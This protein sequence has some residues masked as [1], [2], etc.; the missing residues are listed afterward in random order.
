MTTPT[1]IDF[2]LP[3]SL[4][5]PSPPERRGV[6]RD[7]VR[8]MVLNSLQNEQ[9]H[10]YFYNL[11]RY[12]LPGDVIVLNRSRTIPAVLYATCKTRTEDTCEIRLAKKLSEDTWGVLIGLTDVNIGE[13][14]QIGEQLTATVIGVEADSP[15]HCLQFSKQGADLYA[16]IYALG[17]P[18]RYEYI[19]EQWPLDYYQT[20]YASTPGSVE[21]PSAGR[22]FSW[23][24]LFKLQKKGIKIAYL[25]LHTG[26]SYLL[27][28]KWDHAP[29]KNP[30]SYCL[31]NETMKMITDAK[32][33]QNRII[34]VGTTVVR[35]LE[36]VAI[37]GELAGWTNLYIKRD[38]NRKLVDGIIT[39]L[40]EPKASHLELLTSFVT[41]EQLLAAYRDAMSKNYLWHEFGDMNLIL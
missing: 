24:L 2:Q 29:D 13:E 7:H 4:N 30:E 38:F 40:H 20:V 19:Q 14:F 10:D 32:T 21:M 18:I 12:L 37:T 22:A 27:D 28:D 9:N 11:D 6:R 41:E 5:A 1:S 26:L 15:I 16:S 39:G 8:M 31:S 3:D 23:E 36:T 33:S 17:E 35:A 25:Q 34:A